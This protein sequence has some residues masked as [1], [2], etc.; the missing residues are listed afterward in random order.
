MKSPKKSKAFTLIEILVALII[1]GIVAVTIPMMLQTSTATMKTS[2]K[3]EVF[4]QEFSLL[5]LINSLYFDQNNTVG[6]NYYKDLNATQGDVALLIHKYSN[7]FN[8][9]G[10]EEMNN[11][12][13]RSGTNATVSKI[14]VDKG[15]IKGDDSTYNDVDDYNGFSEKILSSYG[16][17]TLHVRVKYIK[18]NANYSSNDIN[19]TFDYKTPAN[20][21]NI[22]LIT[23]YTN[24]D[25]QNI[26]ISY[27]T[28]N[29]GESKYLSLEEISK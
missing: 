25:S 2:A 10:K 26:S 23:I 14:G 6:D 24:L 27:P 20:F 19:F 21:T 29:I 28:M 22:K 4:Y 16:Y 1:I 9:V 11:N 15:E 8:R 3:E 12:I 5:R 7:G 18:D 17:V 13:L